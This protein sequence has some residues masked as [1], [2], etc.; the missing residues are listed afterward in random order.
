MAGYTTEVRTICEEIAGESCDYSSTD[1][2]IATAAPRIFGNYPIF[3]ETHRATLNEKILRH[4]FFREIGVETVGL[5]KMLLNTRM[6]EIMPYYNKLYESESLR[7]NPLWD[8]DR[9]TEIQGARS[10]STAR[11]GGRNSQR[12]RS[13]GEDSSETI[14]ETGSKTNARAESS[15][16]S[17]TESSNTKSQGQTSDKSASSTGRVNSTTRTENVDEKEA[18]S[19]GESLGTTG[20]ES[21]NV[22]SASSSSGNDSGN[23]TY[24]SETKGASSSGSNKNDERNDKESSWNLFSDT[25]QGGLGGALGQL[26]ED[27]DGGVSSDTNTYLTNATHIYDGKHL[28]GSEAEDSSSASA[29]TLEGSRDNT[30][31]RESSEASATQTENN[32]AT[33][34]ERTNS[35]AGDKNRVGE[36][37]GTES[38]DES[39]ANSSEG[40][41]SRS[42]A[43]TG[44]RVVDNSLASR[45]EESDNRD[46]SKQAQRGES[47]AEAYDEG[48]NEESSHS[49]ANAETQHVYGKSGGRTY[50]RMIAELRDSYLNID[51]MI[52]DKLKDLFMLVY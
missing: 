10:G 21:S 47:E 16:L 35:Y 3:D 18:N 14:G 15:G 50:S 41:S 9:T 7:F 52:I 44:N 51:V 40:T 11:S 48:H 42:D 31:Q 4:Y 43:R 2:I 49:D 17:E 30:T 19:G 33:T 27:V 12:A 34:Q 37:S 45:E 8:I 20:R 22:N 13:V 6:R 24:G 32:S 36:F 29:E 5:W 26:T 38:V 46:T 28:Q 39:S 1:E 23:E 25:P